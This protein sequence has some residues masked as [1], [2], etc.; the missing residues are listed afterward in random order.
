[1]IN[2]KSDKEIILNDFS[3]ETFSQSITTRKL[4]AIKKWVDY[5]VVIYKSIDNGITVGFYNKWSIG[6]LIT[7]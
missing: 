2:Y 5:V 3:L 7:R 6:K 1:M 4:F